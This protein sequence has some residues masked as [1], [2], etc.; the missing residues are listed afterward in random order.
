MLAA[1][2]LIASLVGPT[3]FALVGKFDVGFPALRVLTSLDSAPVIQ[4]L[5]FGR[6]GWALVI[7]AIVLLLVA[8]VVPIAI[9][10]R[11][12]ATLVVLA[13]LAGIVLTLLAVYQLD[14]QDP[15]G[16]Y[17]DHLRWLRVGGYLHLAGWV[18]AFVAAR[19]ARQRVASS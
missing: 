16:S 13:S 2:A 9:V 14:K 19:R 18:L 15:R 1:A 11:A 17:L 5:Y 12:S 8:V 10:A 3:W 4:H 7:V 6:L